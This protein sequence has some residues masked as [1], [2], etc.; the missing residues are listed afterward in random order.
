MTKR[1]FTLV[2]LLAVLTILGLLALLITPTV[3]NAVNKFKEEAY[4][5]QVLTIEA[6]A[7][8]FTSDHLTELPGNFG[9]TIYITLGDLKAEGYLDK[10]IKHPKT[11]AYLP[12]DA[13]IKIMRKKNDYKVEYVKDSGTLSMNSN[14]KKNTPTIRLTGDKIMTIRVGSTYAEPGAIAYDASK[15][16][17]SS[18]MTKT[19]KKGTTTVATINTNNGGIYTIYYK[20]TN[21]NMTQV[22]TRT[23]VVESN[24][25][26]TS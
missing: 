6:A 16:N 14:I 7:G 23:V 10:D 18:G 24:P 9:D 2:E 15:N 25:G 21:Q 4:E 12:N 26:V 1:G 22:I 17:I 20:I 3:F 11:N 8:D 13:L 5:K 19:I